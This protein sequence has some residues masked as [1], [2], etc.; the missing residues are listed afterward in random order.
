MSEILN[1]AI[2]SSSALTFY[3]KSNELI[4]RKEKQDANKGKLITQI[5]KAY[6]FKSTIYE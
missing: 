2:S 3:E 5:L 6:A 4:T 1:V